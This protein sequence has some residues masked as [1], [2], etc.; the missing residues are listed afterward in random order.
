MTEGASDLVTNP[1][2]EDNVFTFGVVNT[3]HYTNHRGE[4]SLRTVVPLYVQWGRP[5]DFCPNSPEK[6]DEWH[7]VC[8]DLDKKATR[9]FRFSKI[10]PR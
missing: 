2:C 6:D 1:K 3:F 8:I 4:W 10:D 7:L 9:H 5:C